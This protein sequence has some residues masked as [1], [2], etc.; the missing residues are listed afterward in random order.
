MGQIQDGRPFG[1][2][3]HHARQGP[4]GLRHVGHTR[5]RIFGPEVGGLIFSAPLPGTVGRIDHDQA[6]QATTY[7]HYQ[8]HGN[9]PWVGFTWRYDSG[10]VSSGVPDLASALSLT[11]DQQ[12]AI[13]FYCGSNVASL[14]N[15][16]TSCGS[17]NW[18]AKQISIPA[19]GTENDDTNPAHVVGRHVLSLSIGIDNLFRTDHYHWTLRLTAQNL[20]NTQRL[21]NFLSTCAGTHWLAPRSLRAQLALE[22]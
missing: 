14:T 8:F 7:V 6:L 13:G 9:G 22:F 19:P 20:T 5:A 1:P 2:P 3:V 11:A 12:A 18:G 15:R 21:Y 4:L 17:S 10:I 16:I